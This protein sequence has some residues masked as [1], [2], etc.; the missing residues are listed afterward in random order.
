MH[1]FAAILK[2]EAIDSLIMSADPVFFD[3][4]GR[5]WRIARWLLIALL[6]LIVALPAAFV[7]S[8][9]RIGKVPQVFEDPRPHT[10]VTADRFHFL[11]RPAHKHASN[12]ID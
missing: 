2:I 3:E 4:S 12:S 11:K 10:I 5:R 7:I 8:A 9:V 1:D 6:T